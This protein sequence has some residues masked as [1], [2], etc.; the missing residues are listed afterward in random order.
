MGS[1]ALCSGWRGV[2]ALALAVGLYGHG[3]HSW[4][5]FAILFL[6]PDVSMA[7]YLA[8][9]RIG[10]LCYN[11]AHTYVLPA[12]VGAALWMLGRSLAVPMIWVA[13]IGFDRMLG[14]GLKYRDGFGFTHLGRIGRTKA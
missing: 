3:G 5:W 10:A 14:Y 2:A 1:R 12:I 7:G 6:T 13:H 9:P 4:V 11:I 8:G